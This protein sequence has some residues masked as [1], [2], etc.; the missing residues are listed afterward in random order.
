MVFKIKTSIKTMEYF[1]E[2]GVLFDI[3]IANAGVSGGTAG[4]FETDESFK[5]LHFFE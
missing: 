5:K 2:I 1:E 3:V 4:G